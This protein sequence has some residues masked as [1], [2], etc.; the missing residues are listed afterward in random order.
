MYKFLRLTRLPV[1]I[2]GLILVWVADRYLAAETY[3]AVLRISGAVIAA[4]GVLMTLALSF[5]TSRGELFGESKSWRRLSVW[6]IVLFAGL[7]GYFVYGAVL[8]DAV[9]PQTAGQKVL[10][11]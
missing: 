8:G 1:F 10:L 3:H 7:I 6:Q 4:L 9:A 11:G 2:L 5:M